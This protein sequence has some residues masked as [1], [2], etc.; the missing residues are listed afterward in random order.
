VTHLFTQ[1]LGLKKGHP[2]NSYALLTDSVKLSKIVA[3]ATRN[4]LIVNSEPVLNSNCIYK[5]MENV[6]HAFISSFGAYLGNGL[7]LIC[8]F[9]QL[10]GFKEWLVSCP[11]HALSQGKGSH[12]Y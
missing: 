10:L 4:L 7:A 6:L 11:D 3:E 12:D 9:A 2:L 5:L 8:L 1:L